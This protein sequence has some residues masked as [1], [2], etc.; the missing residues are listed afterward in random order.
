MNNNK[1]E[2]IFGECNTDI[3]PDAY[4]INNVISQPFM[5]VLGN[6]IVKIKKY[7]DYIQLYLGK[8]IK[9]EK[10]L[11][12]NNK[13]NK[14]YYI[15]GDFNENKLHKKL[16]DNVMIMKYLKE[17]KN[18]VEIEL[19]IG[20][21]SLWAIV[22]C[23]STDRHIYCDFIEQ[24]VYFNSYIDEEYRKLYDNFNLNV[25]KKYNNAVG[26]KLDI[27]RY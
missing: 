19:K 15:L 1:K 7:I 20:I 2:K 26:Y 6:Y 22:N 14:I 27:N 23:I 5:S 25:I 21:E 11:V 17:V 16:D 3:I 4:F 8:I 9:Y 12:L 13:F 10:K 24:V 18:L